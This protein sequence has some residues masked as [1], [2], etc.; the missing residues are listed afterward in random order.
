MAP[1]LK[2]QEQTL[3]FRRKFM[4]KLLFIFCLILTGCV[5]ID[6]YP[7]ATV[8]KFDLTRDELKN[9]KHMALQGNLGAA[10]KVASYYS[11]V[12]N[13]QIES[14]K[15][16]SLAADLGSDSAIKNLYSILIDS[17][18]KENFQ[19][20]LHYLN[21]AAMGGDPDAQYL[22]GEVY[23]HSNFIK[24]DTKE[25]YQWFLKSAQ[26]GHL[27]GA[28]RCSQLLLEGEGVLKSYDDSYFWARVSIQRVAHGSAL[29]KKLL[30]LLL[31]IEPNLTEYEKR[32]IEERVNKTKGLP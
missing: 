23:E 27:G 26:Q 28:I 29:E 9:F 20:G 4:P 14:I 8:H 32:Q 31:S 10:N 21:I 5:V 24:K 25:A 12:K 15:W 19:V 1:I 22:M 16:Y 11:F 17:T 30:D 18:D 3:S 6:N 13:N 2:T 7:I